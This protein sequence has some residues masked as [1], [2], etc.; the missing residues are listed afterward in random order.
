MQAPAAN[1]KDSAESMLETFALSNISPQ[2][3]RGF[4]R[5]YWARFERFVQL[6]TR[7]CDDVYVVTGPLYLPTPTPSGYMMQHPMIGEVHP[8]C[9]PTCILQAVIMPTVDMHGAG[10]LMGIVLLPAGQPPRMVAVP[11]HFFKVVLAERSVTADDGSAS[12]KAVLGAFV[13]PNAHL[14]PDI[15]L[16][17]FSVPLLSLEEAAGTFLSCLYSSSSNRC[18]LPLFRRPVFM[19]QCPVNCRSAG[20]PWLPQCRAPHRAG[21]GSAFPPTQGQAAAGGQGLGAHAIRATAA[22]AACRDC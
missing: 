17:A 19:Q 9:A 18:G 6:M 10:V 16:T 21:R 15:P 2:V 3:G 8:C 20:V 22:F 14:Q 1:H 12:T 13:L 4:N 11:T 7:S 5:D